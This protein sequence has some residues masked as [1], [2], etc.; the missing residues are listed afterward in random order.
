MRLRET[1]D[2]TQDR[3]SSS[4]SSIEKR[5]FP[6]FLFLFPPPLP[7]CS[8]LSTPSRPG[9]KEE[10]W[11]VSEHVFMIIW[12]LYRDIGLERQ[13]RGGEHAMSDLSEW[14]IKSFSH[15][16]F[17]HRTRIHESLFLPACRDEQMRKSERRWRSYCQR[18]ICCAPESS[19]SSTYAYDMLRTASL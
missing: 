19:F 5:L 6:Y 14:I 15:G 2:K 11:D 18:A 13:R 17:L 12:E 1:Q 7:P 16:F 10:R 8:S 3:E 4:S 9:E